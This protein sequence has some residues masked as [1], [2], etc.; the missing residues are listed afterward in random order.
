MVKLSA[1][2][3][4][5]SAEVTFVQK[6]A[7][8]AKFSAKAGEIGQ[9]LCKKVGLVKLSVETSWIDQT[10]CRSG[11]DWSNFLCKK[12]VKICA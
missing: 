2:L 11:W 7:G 3:G 10:L 12:E 9:R 5:T 4:R 8:L 1:E 6:W